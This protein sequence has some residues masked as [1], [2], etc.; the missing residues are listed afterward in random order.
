MKVILKTNISKLGLKYDQVNVKP[1]YARNYLFPKE[2]A[3]L[4]TSKTI[5]ENN[6]ILKQR[7]NKE[8][9]LIK[10]AQTI[11][12]NINNITLNIKVNIGMDGK[13]FG[14]IN[15]QNIFNELLKHG[16][17]IEDKKKIIIDNNIK[18]LGK[19]YANICLHPNV[20]IKIPFNVIN[21]KTNNNIK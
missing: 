11:A 8:K 17:E 2:Y 14:K 15:N 13:L 6:E 1:G 5:K 19:Y 9:Y 3:V 20:E 12:K 7:L 21:I 18:S 10:K 4:A 16:I